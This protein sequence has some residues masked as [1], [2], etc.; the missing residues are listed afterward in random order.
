VTNQPYLLFV[1]CVAH[2]SLLL[3][4]EQQAQNNDN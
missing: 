4:M 1:A 2:I 3:S